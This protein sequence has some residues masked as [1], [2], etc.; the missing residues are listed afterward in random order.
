MTGSEIATLMWQRF[1]S[2]IKVTYLNEEKQYLGT[3][4][5]ARVTQLA[6]EAGLTRI[7]THDRMAQWVRNPQ[8][9]GIPNS[10]GWTSF[11]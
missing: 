7:A 2:H 4:G 5:L 1:G 8:Q 11:P 6:E 9:M 3:G 10:P